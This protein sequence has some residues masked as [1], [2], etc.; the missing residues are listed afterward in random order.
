MDSMFPTTAPVDQT[1]GTWAELH[2][3]TYAKLASCEQ[4]LRE[5]KRQVWFFR[6]FIQ[7][8][9]LDDQFDEYAIGMGIFDT[10]NEGGLI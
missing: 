7:R 10:P 4:A 2:T 9:R 5:A 1:P 6:D 8:Y 3:E